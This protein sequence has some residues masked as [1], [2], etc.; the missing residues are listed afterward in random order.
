MSSRYNHKLVE[1][2]WQ[3]KWE[4]KKVFE[5]K[6]ND[7]KKYYVLEMFPYPSGK[8]HMGHVRNYTLGDVVARYKKMNGYNVM[9]P[10]GWDAFGLPAEN[11]ALVE[12]KNPADWTYQ[13]IKTMKK[14]LQTMGLSLDWKRE[15][16]TCHPDYYKHEQAFFIDLLNNKLAYKKESEVNWDP[17]DKTVLANEQV[18]DGRGWRSGAIVERKKLSQWFLKIS[19]YS[20]ELLED[21]KKLDDWPEKV[22]LMQSNW[23]GR[24]DGVVIKFKLVSA[25]SEINEIEVFTTRH[26]TLF[27]ASFCAISIEHPLTKKIIQKDK[28]AA[29]FVKDCENIDQEKIKRGYR[30][31]LFV[32]HPL[33]KDKRLPVFVSNFVLMEYGSGAVFGCPAHDQRDLEFAIKYGLPVIP[34]ILPAD[35]DLKNKS[36]WCKEQLKDKKKPMKGEAFVGE[37]ILINSEFLNNK[38]INE[39]KKTVLEELIKNKIGKKQ[40]NYKLRDWG[41]SRQR[42]WGCPI[43]V[44]YKEDGSIQA[45]RKEDLPVELPKINN[46]NHSSS[47]TLSD[48]NDWKNTACPSTGMKAIRETD[49]F[50]T[51]FE[52]SWYYLR[53]CNPRLKEPFEKN[54]I[55]YW[56]PVD[57]YIGGIEHAILHLLYSRFFTKALR[58]LG[59]INID[60]PFRGLFT[61]GMVTHKTFKSEN[62]EWLDPEEVVVDSGVFL[63]KGGK[64]VFVGKIEKMSKSKKNVINPSNI[65]NLYG[66]DT[67]RW[68][69]LSDSPP[70]RDLEWTD[71]GV[72]AAHKFINK[73]WELSKSINKYS[74]PKKLE[75]FD[76]DTFNKLINDVSVNIEQFHFNKSVANIYEYVNYL[77]KLVSS[78]KI[79]KSFLENALKNLAI[80][81]HPF[82]PHIS[83]E[84][85]CLFGGE[86]LCVNASWP[87]VKYSI[88][89]KKIKLPIQ[90]NGITRSLLTINNSLDKNTIIK[91]AKNDKKIT[92][93]IKSKEVIRT[94]YVPGKILNFV[95][96]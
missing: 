57:Q 22:K 12:K 8:I 24:S 55:N 77:S 73:L 74:E 38:T 68:F 87:K 39:A 67:A 15:I 89:K 94:I 21:L 33:I 5:T 1:K 63:D 48:L 17:V 60:E 18:I 30:T 44:I 81:M 51:F 4:D 65:I 20:E 2:K 95:I 7:K 93:R 90:I 16:A 49:T 3:T 11:A 42:Y 29:S 26:D 84:I 91:V 54:E 37:G 32:Q 25:L 56:L 19:K 88:N 70:E 85:W 53:Y 64:K 23:I 41:I 58:D 28:G 71:R 69:M 75:V 43:P 46:F 45:V 34:V 66:A 10:M 47:I 83:E 79:G 96:K 35:I 78:K 13:N 72:A 40:T 82:I 31:N 62:G 92:K 59:Y 61:Q 27:G 52:S 86:G 36:K 9:H 50:D 80:I 14:Q 76:L 6:I